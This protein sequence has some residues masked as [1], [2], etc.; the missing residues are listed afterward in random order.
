[1]DVVQSNTRLKYQCANMTFPTRAG[2]IDCFKKWCTNEGIQKSTT[3]IYY[4]MI[5]LWK[6]Q[7]EL[8]WGLAN[9]QLLIQFTSREE[10]LISNSYPLNRVEWRRFFLIIN[11][12][13]YL[14][15]KLSTWIWIIQREPQ[16]D[17]LFSTKVH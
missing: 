14:T 16:K 1:M 5:R 6:Y 7:W 4:K 3:S 11:Y 15:Y 17:L 13:I 12:Y 2:T 10:I 9:A 8:L